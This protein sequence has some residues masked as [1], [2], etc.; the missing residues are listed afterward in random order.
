MN[1]YLLDTCCFLWL[2]AGDDKLPE[3]MRDII[4]LPENEIFVSSISAWEIII[5]HQAGKLP[6][7]QK[8]DVFVRQQR[9]AHLLTS[10]PIAE[11]HVL[12]LA[13]LPDFHR[14]P[15]DRMLVCQAIAEGLTILT[16][17]EAVTQYPVRTLW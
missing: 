4:R 17:D 3:P 14:D 7:P 15:F 10:L 1:R 6:L 13:K 12:T 16:P 11:A 9:E 2:V 5:K 8:P